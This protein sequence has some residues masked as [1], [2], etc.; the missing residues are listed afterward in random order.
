MSSNL[1]VRT[2]RRGILTI[3]AKTAQKIR[4]TSVSRARLAR[5]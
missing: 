3:P 2:V 4:L 1:M 5:G